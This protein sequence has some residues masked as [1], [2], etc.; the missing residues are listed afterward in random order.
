MTS[1]TLHA[2]HTPQ[3]AAAWLRSRVTG[4]LHTDSRRVLQG[5]GFIAWP[6]GVRDG[7]AFGRC[8]ATTCH[9]GVGG[10]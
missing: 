1:R 10:A 5:D 2:L 6:G 9:C 3:E 7:R 8:V 4:E